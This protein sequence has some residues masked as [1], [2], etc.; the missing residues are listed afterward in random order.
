MELWAP[1]RYSS[2][3]ERIEDGISK[4]LARLVDRQR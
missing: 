2:D 4:S 1:E 3:I